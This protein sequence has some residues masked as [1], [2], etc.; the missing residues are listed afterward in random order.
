MGI[1]L[2]EIAIVLV[3]FLVIF[4]AKKLPELGKGLGSGMREFKEG[5]SGDD[6][7]SPQQIASTP[8]SPTGAPAQPAS[9]VARVETPDAAPGAHPDPDAP[10]AAPRTEE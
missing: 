9:P 2:P 10:A 4:G 8:S 7:K 6:A 1:G 5:I 3:I